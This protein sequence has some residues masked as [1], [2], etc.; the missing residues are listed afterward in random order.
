MLGICPLYNDNQYYNF[1]DTFFGDSI[2]KLM[3]HDNY[4]PDTDILNLSN[5]MSL[6]LSI[7]CQSQ[8]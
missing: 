2:D 4:Y 7:G 5:C 8:G 1:V 6:V 3:G